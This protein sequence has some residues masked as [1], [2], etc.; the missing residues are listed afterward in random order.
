VFLS[1][2]FGNVLGSRGSVLE[3]FRAQ[4]ASGGP[5]TVTSPDATRYFMT[6]EEAVQLVIQAGAVGRSGEVLALDM[7]E[8]VRIADVAHRLAATAPRHI[9]VV[10]TGLRPGEKLHE[11]RLGQDESDDRAVHPLIS[12]ATVPPLSPEDAWAL[13]PQVE[14]TLVRESLRALCQ[15][16]AGRPATP[17]LE[18]PSVGDGAQFR[19]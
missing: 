5:L 7:G 15:P 14:D 11:V 9:E 19:R 6:V 1:V 4:L 10:M 18:G 8:P 16:A 17:E 12:H 3:S 13:D 2:R